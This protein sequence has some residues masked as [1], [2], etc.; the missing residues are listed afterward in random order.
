MLDVNI[1]HGATTKLRTVFQS[2]T[3]KQCELWQ[4]IT[5][6][7][8]TIF[9]TGL[10][11]EGFTCIAQGSRMYASDATKVESIDFWSISAEGHGNKSYNEGAKTSYFISH[12]D[13]STN[14]KID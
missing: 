12:E 5:K 1:N 11:G 9:N 10:V 6:Q 3:D 13:D 7:H 4:F 2:Y 8:L 14:L